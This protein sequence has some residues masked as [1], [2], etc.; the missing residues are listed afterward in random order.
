M[1]K[2][3]TDLFD[4]DQIRSQDDIDCV[5]RQLLSRSMVDAQGWIP[6][7]AFMQLKKI[8]FPGHENMVQLLR[9]SQYFEV[10]GAEKKELFRLSDTKKLNR[11]VKLVQKASVSKKATKWVVEEI[12]PSL[13]VGII[14]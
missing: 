3:I 2:Q 11:W 4:T 10:K 1:R 7:S 14:S 13:F 8:Y 12:Q 5:D 9:E 6:I